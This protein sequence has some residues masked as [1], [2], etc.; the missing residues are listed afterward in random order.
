MRNATVK[1]LGIEKIYEVTKNMAHFKIMLPSGNYK[2]EIICHEYETR[3]LDV[4]IESDNITFVKVVLKTQD[5][6][7]QVE[8]HEPKAGE[9]LIGTGLRG[10]FNKNK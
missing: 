7:G 1:I 9:G 4:K 8:T 10:K 5:T 2:L 6:Q 3:L